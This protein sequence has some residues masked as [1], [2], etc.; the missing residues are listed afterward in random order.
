MSYLM[1]IRRAFIAFDYRQCKT[2]GEMFKTY[3]YRWQHCLRCRALRAMD[4]SVTDTTAWRPKAVTHFSGMFGAPCSLC[5]GQH[6][7]RWMICQQCGSG[8]RPQR[9][10]KE[11]DWP[12]RFVRGRSDTVYCSNACRQRAYRERKAK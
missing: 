3:D 6:W 1:A 5:G 10:S 2:C 11:G 4:R 9:T 12:Y 7:A 8:Y